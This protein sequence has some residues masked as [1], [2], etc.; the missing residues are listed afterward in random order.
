MPKIRCSSLTLGELLPLLA[1][2]VMLVVML[3]GFSYAS[4]RTS[5]RK[6]AVSHGYAQWVVT[7]D[8][9]TMFRW[10]GAQP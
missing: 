4:G 8:G 1:I 6:E 3:C 5:V 9:D 10:K 7:P 2:P